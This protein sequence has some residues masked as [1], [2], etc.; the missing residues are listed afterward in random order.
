MDCTP[1]EAKDAFAKDLQ[2]TT[3][4][5]VLLLALLIIKFFNCDASTVLSWAHEVLQVDGQVVDGQHFV[6]ERPAE[7]SHPEDGEWQAA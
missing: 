4:S 5:E 3:P 2:P 6:L 1:V 7:G